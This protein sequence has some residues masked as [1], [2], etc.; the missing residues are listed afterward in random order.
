MCKSV[1]KLVSVKVAAKSVGVKE[2]LC[3]SW[4]VQ[5]LVCVEAGVCKNLEIKQKGVKLVDASGMPDVR[6]HAEKAMS[7]EEK[8]E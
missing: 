3:K 1:I 2:C 5:K 7:A 6:V 8:Q 4:P